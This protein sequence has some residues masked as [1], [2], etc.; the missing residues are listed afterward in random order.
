MP[1]PSVLEFTVPESHHHTLELVAQV[2]ATDVATAQA[3]QREAKQ[4]EHVAQAKLTRSAER[5]LLETSKDKLPD[6]VVPPGSR[7]NVDFDK[8]TIKVQTP[9]KQ[10]PTPPRV[11]QG[12]KAK[13]GAQAS[14]T[15]LPPADAPQA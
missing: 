1:R 9:E 8:R 6:G 2:Y 13:K 5:L 7:I 14:T 12:K 15:P 4:A 11:I 3:K 10:E